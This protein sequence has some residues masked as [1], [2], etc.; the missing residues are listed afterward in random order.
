MAWLMVDHH[1]QFHEF[2][3]DFGRLDPHAFVASSP[4]QNGFR[5]ADF[6]LN[7]LGTVISVFG[8]SRPGA[9]TFCLGSRS[10]D[11]KGLAPWI[12]P[13]I[14]MILEGPLLGLRDHPEP[15]GWACL[16]PSLHIFGV[17][18]LRPAPLFFPYGW[19]AGRG[20][21]GRWGGGAA[22]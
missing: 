4:T 7:G 18:S 5:N 15:P 22:G 19:G 17:S 10:K 6:S 11:K 3:D 8:H 1:P 16:L 14:V 2:F 9:A 21:P 13:N 20:T 12:L